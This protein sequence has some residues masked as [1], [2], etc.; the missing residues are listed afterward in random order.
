MMKFYAYTQETYHDEK[1]A[2]RDCEENV[3]VIAAPSENDA[4]EAFARI[5]DEQIRA[6]GNEPEETDFDFVVA[7]FHEDLTE[8]MSYSEYNYDEV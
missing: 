7:E 1:F 5:I 2:I 8:T 4:R 6:I 3:I